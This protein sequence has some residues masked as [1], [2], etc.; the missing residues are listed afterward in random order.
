MPVSYRV[1]IDIGGTF[2]D[3]VAFDGGN[4]VACSFKVASRP[5]EPGGEVK[6]VIRILDETY[7]IA[8][9][10]IEHFT[11][12]T[13]VGLNTVVQRSGPQLALLTTR[14][15]EDVLELGRLRVPKQ[16]DLLSVRPLPLIARP[17][18][19]GITERIGP[20]GAEVLPVEQAD[21][22]AAVERAVADGA[23]GIVVSFL[24]AYRNAAHEQA[25]KHRIQALR[26]DLP[27]TCSSEVWP[28]IREYERTVTAGVSAYV[29]PAVS[30]YLDRLQSNMTTAGL[31]TPLL[32]TK[33]NGGVM[34]AEA[35]KEAGVQMILSGPAC[36]V[37]A[38]AAVAEALALDRVIALDVG[39]TT[40]DISVLVDGEIPYATETSV[41]DFKVASPCVSIS[42]VGRGGGSIVWA[43]SHGV[44]HVGPRSAGA[45][46]GPICYRRG[47][48][49]LTLTDVLA[50]WGLLDNA[51]ISAIDDLDIEGARRG[52]AALAG[53]LGIAEDELI[54][55][56]IRVAV[57]GVYTEVNAVMAEQAVDPRE[58]SLL[59]F[60]GAGPMIGTLLARELGTTS[61][62]VPPNP[63][64]LCALGGLV[65]DVRNDFVRACYAPATPAG[66]ELVTASLVELDGQV[67]RW[68]EE[69]E[70]PGDNCDVRYSV[71]AR[72]GGQGHEIDVLVERAWFTEGQL[73]RIADAFH[74]LHKRLYGHDQPDNAVELTAL[75]ATA[76]I[77]EAKQPFHEIESPGGAEDGKVTQVLRIDGKPT[78]VQ[79]HRREELR[80]DQELIGPAI[81]VQADTTTYISP[82]WRALIDPFGNIVMRDHGKEQ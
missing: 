70:Q 59:A 37:A 51:P 24:H 76:V 6:E 66:K 22:D 21:V 42:S 74:R 33:S 80:R 9:A 49:E 43:D 73:D 15:F 16:S 58:F 3:I 17:L 38:A 40:A 20:D 27:V 4:R 47:G 67:A 23:E 68:R 35:A 71:E 19:F 65:A 44:V 48:T 28:V 57:S 5:D 64:T 60:G 39:G 30:A 81:V 79:V 26:P 46:P 69:H 10:A 55:L 31:S 41:G 8:P 54:D 14:G 36:G 72:Y 62:V 61:V 7:G 32:V 56:V 11:H 12:G 34:S 18:V 45:R 77:A 78:E 50:A 52:L 53:E 75:K 29:Q 63:G 13:T 82:G 2:T 25:V 1:S